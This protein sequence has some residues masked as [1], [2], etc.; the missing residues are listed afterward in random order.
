MA[1]G[2]SIRVQAATTEGSSNIPGR[3][4]A[5]APVPAGWKLTTTQPPGEPLRLGPL[6][7]TRCTTTA[8]SG[9]LSGQPAAGLVPAGWKSTTTSLTGWIVA[10]SALYQQ[11]TDRSIWQYAGTPCNGTSCP[12]W[13]E[14][15]DNPNTGNREIFAGQGTVYQLHESDASVWQYTGTPCN[16]TSC[17]GWVRL[18]DNTSTWNIVAGPA[19]FYPNE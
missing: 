15:D 12:G 6:R 4:A 14:L 11:H 1:P 19:N 10:G 5:G 9:S 8:Q 18:D 16:G 3:P 13:F 2:E 17:P 7:S